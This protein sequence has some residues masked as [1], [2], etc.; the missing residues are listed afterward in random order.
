MLP[1][2]AD[3]EAFAAR[4]EE[5]LNLPA[6][7]LLRLRERAREACRQTFDLTTC[8]RELETWL[9]HIIDTRHK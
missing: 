4:I 5:A 9:R 1:R 2:D 7:D 3:D 8:T 6:P